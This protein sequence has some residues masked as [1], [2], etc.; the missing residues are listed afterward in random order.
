MHG[1][2]LH[3]QGTQRDDLMGFADAQP[4]PPPGGPSPINLGIFSQRTT[5]GRR[6]SGVPSGPRNRAGAPDPVARHRFDLA[7]ELHAMPGFTLSQLPLLQRV[8]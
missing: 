7:G 2:S 8:T 1:P 5:S 6:R 3:S 4:I